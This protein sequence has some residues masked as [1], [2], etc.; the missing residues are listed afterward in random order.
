[1]NIEANW[2]KSHENP[3]SVLEFQHEGF[4]QYL[5]FGQDCFRPR[6]FQFII[7]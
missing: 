5:K 6:S 7:Y 1:M 2:V 4:P 3:N